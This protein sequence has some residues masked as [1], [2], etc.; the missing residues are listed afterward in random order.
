MLFDLMVKW[1]M[2]YCFL[3]MY[4]GGDVEFGVWVV[5]MIGL[6]YFEKFLILMVGV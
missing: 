2:Y 4:V 1:E 5:E 6:V 3:V